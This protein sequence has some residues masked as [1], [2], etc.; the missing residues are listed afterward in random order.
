M[1][2]LSQG[3]WDPADSNKLKVDAAIYPRRKHPRDGRPHWGRQRA[4]IEFKRGGTEND[5]Y[6]DF[7][8]DAQAKK[9]T[10]VRGQLA[11]YSA[12]SFARQQRTANF[13]FLIIGETARITRW[14]RGGT[15]FTEAFNYV[16][17]PD[18]MCEFLWRF[19]L[20][21]KEDQGLDPTAKL[22]TRSCNQFKLMDRIA[23]GPLDGEPEDICA[24]EGTTV[25][26]PVASSV[27]VFKYVRE[28]F[29]ASLADDAP[30]YRLSVP[31]DG[32]GNKYYLVGK[33]VFEAS[34]MVGRGTRGYIAVDVHTKQF[35]WL[36]DVWRAYYINVHPEGEILSKL[37]Q[38]NV[39]RIPTLLYAGD[40]RQE[41]QMHR[42]W[43]Q[44]SEV[45][46]SGETSGGSRGSKRDC[47][48]ASKSTDKNQH[49]QPRIRRL[50]HYRLI[51]KEVGLRLEEIKSSRKH[52]Q[53]VSDCVEGVSLSLRAT[54]CADLIGQRMKM[55]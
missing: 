46:D 6:Q 33:P 54:G 9:P 10:E 49:K 3:N 35:V 53:V 18:L 48:G 37:H 30:R 44:D 52:I 47:S 45:Q 34:S 20:L 36:K 23:Q 38:A 15:I 14:E 39:S 2:C 29:A 31:T 19:S 55:Q 25:P 1:V 21:S 17:D 41:T 7:D 5:P 50:S 16:E 24:D 32:E 4:L 26:L 51:V 28:R 13:L 27:G 11:S 22:L 8:G 43:K 42:H 12:Y 40:L